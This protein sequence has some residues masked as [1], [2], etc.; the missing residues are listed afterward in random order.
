VTKH[1]ELIKTFGDRLRA[2]RGYAGLSRTDIERRYGISEASIKSW[3]TS[4]N[5]VVTKKSLDR[6]VEV[7]KELGIHCT[8]KW[9]TLGLGP[10][11]FSPISSEI[12][13]DED[14]EES[15]DLDREH[16]KETYPAHIHYRINTD[17]LQ[18]WFFNQDLVA[19]HQLL[20][21]QYPQKLGAFCVFRMPD[22]KVI[23]GRLVNGS[24]PEK[25]SILQDLFFETSDALIVDADFLNA[26]EILAVIK[27]PW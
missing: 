23:A 2:L 6:L 8:S 26:Y 19:G 11:P 7:F 5:K 3:E 27:E 13:E 25:F 18:P 4:T 12:N 10:N 20:S 21:Q 9:L 16:F 17:A 14:L 1:N 22:N 15:E 24:K